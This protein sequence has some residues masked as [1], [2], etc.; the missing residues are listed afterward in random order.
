MVFDFSLLAR[1]GQFVCNM[2]QQHSIY[3]VTKQPSAR[4]VLL[5]CFSDDCYHF[6]MCLRDSVRHAGC[7]LGYN[8]VYKP[9]SL[10]NGPLRAYLIHST[11]QSTRRIYSSCINHCYLSLLLSS[12]IPFSAVKFICTSII[13]NYIV[14]VALE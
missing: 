5:L 10:I 2:K 11:H 12:Q 13:I 3:T 8:T 14:G 1:Q 7:R 4:V 6:V 9:V